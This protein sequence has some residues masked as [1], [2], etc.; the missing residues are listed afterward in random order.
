MKRLVLFLCGITHSFS[1]NSFVTYLTPTF[2]RFS[3]SRCPLWPTLHPGGL[4][5]I[6]Y[7]PPNSIFSLVSL[8]FSF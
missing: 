3:T 6:W 7:T 4:V 5:R 8:S 1:C 2:P